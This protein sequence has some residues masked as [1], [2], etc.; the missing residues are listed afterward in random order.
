[1]F[2]RR[3]ASTERSEASC[4]SDPGPSCAPL[5]GAALEAAL[6]PP[7]APSGPAL[8]GPSLETALKRVG[9]AAA[10]AARPAKRR[11]PVKQARA[12]ALARQ[13]FEQLDAM[14]LEVE[15]DA[16]AHIWAADAHNSRPL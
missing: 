3:S 15:I 14:E 16:P 5:A 13:F 7:P 10:A 11:T 2:A 8:T 12:S 1:V 6:K 4:S 9:C